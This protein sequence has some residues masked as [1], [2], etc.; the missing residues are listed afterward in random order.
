L[1]ST[2][3]GTPLYVSPEVLKG[4]EYNQKIDI[5]AVGILTY[6]LLIGRVPFKI[7]T[8]ADMAKIVNCKII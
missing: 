2:F 5:W 8:E 1:R 7:N 6:E 4:D 3:C